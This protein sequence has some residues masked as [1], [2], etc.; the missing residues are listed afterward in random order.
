MSLI[1]S[2][3]EGTR[4]FDIDEFVSF[5]RYYKIII[6]KKHNIKVVAWNLAEEFGFTKK[7]KPIK[8]DY[9]VQELKK[10]A[11]EWEE[12]LCGSSF[13]SLCAL[14]LFPASPTATIYQSQSLK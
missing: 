4:E 1:L 6:T 7:F 8:K 11:V 9:D 3:P 2:T 13:F 5:F 12:K 14:S 10:I